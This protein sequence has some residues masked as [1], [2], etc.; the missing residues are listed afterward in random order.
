MQFKVLIDSTFKSR[1]Y[2]GGMD[3]GVK[4]TYWVFIF[5]KLHFN[6]LSL[7]F[8]DVGYVNLLAGRRRSSI[9]SFV[10]AAVVGD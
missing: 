4:W 6:K 8:K 3:P 9:G 7:S 2:R 10:V 1:V 5:L